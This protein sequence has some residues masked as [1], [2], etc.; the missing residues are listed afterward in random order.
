M[1]VYN[2]CIV[3][4]NIYYSVT[5]K[6]NFLSFPLK[7]LTEWHNLVAADK[8]HVLGCLGGFIVLTILTY[9]VFEPGIEKGETHVSPS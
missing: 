9:T 8:E 4:K 1:M 6:N 7:Q 2:N 5:K 3:T